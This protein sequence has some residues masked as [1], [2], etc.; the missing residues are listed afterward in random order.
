MYMPVSPEQ[1]KVQESCVLPS[2]SHVVYGLP[3]WGLVGMAEA[4]SREAKE[5]V[6]KQGGDLPFQASAKLNTGGGGVGGKP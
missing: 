6:E 2:P 1:L 3:L 5:V 4:P